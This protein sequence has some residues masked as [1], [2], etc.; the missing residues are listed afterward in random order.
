MSPPLTTFLST[1]DDWDRRATIEQLAIGGAYAWHG[2]MS[3][4]F[5]CAAAVNNE[6]AKKTLEDIGR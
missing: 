6:K 4:S 2:L 5:P 3:P 1:A